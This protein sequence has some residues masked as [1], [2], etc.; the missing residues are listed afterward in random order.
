M[1]RSMVLISALV[2]VYLLNVLT[3]RSLW[4]TKQLIS[5][6]LHNSYLGPAQ[7]SDCDTV[8]YTVGTD[9]TGFIQ[10][11]HVDGYRGDRPDSVKYCSRLQQKTLTI[12]PGELF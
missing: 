8:W 9:T 10:Y 1:T 4:Q 11:W 5:A 7:R 6:T 3:L 12:T 2:I